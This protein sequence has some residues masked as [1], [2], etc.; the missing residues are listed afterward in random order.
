MSYHIFISCKLAQVA[1]VFAVVSVRYSP[2][3]AG[4]DYRKKMG[5]L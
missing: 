4:G 1:Q 3:Y 5:F 2:F